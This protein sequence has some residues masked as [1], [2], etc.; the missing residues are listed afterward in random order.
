MQNPSPL[1]STRII[2]I[3]SGKGGAGKTTVSTHLAMALSQ[4]GNSVILLDADLG[5]ANAQ[6]LLG[7]R[8]SFNLSHVVSGVKSLQEVMLEVRPQYHLIPGAS[9]VKF[10]ASLTHEQKQA[11]VDAFAGLKHQPNYI[12]IDTAAGISSDVLI[13]LA[14]SH[15]R[16]VVVKDDP[17]SIADAYGIIKVMHQDDHLDRIWL[18]SNQVDNE[19]HGRN[20]YQRIANVSQRFLGLDL[21]YLGSIEA[22]DLVLSAQRKYQLVQEYAPGSSAARDFRRIADHITQL[23]QQG[24]LEDEVSLQNSLFTKPN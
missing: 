6:L 15:M 7:I 23:N 13:F 11:L 1:R 4:M 18:V 14:A 19:H 9:G 22:D 17:S 20:L 5:L 21:G 16:V 2:A 12:I 3:T 8:T 10:M 24:V